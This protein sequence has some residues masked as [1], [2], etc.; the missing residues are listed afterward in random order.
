MPESVYKVI[1]LIG[2]SE[3][4]WEKAT[5]AAVARAG[6]TLRDLQDRRG[7][8]ARRDHRE[9]QGHQLPSQ[10][11]GV[12]QVRER[13]GPNRIRATQSAGG[14]RAIPVRLTSV[15]RPHWVIPYDAHRATSP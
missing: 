4:S 14:I 8:R 9:R 3:E 12:V 1:E 15:A 11:Q 2:T 13:L 7:E 10:A 5:A 6:E